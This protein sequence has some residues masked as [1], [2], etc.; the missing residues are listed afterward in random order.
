MC[1]PA[2]PSC[3]ARWPSSTL[4][5]LSTISG[6]ER[7]ADL[8]NRERPDVIFVDAPVS[9]SK[10]PA[11]QGRLTIFASGP[12][13]ARSRVAPLFDALGER[14]IWVGG[15]G[16]GSRLKLVNNT[17]LAFESEGVAASVA[18][19]RRSG[20][21]SETVVDVIGGGPLTSSW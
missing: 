17:W 8:V 10:D 12:D 16:A 3:R 1:L 2:V 19:A 4:R 11:A 7:V 15:V 20:L 6:G 18:L 5:N 13:E 9:G 14:T 21:Q